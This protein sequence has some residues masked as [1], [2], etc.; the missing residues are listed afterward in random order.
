MKTLKSFMSFFTPSRKYKRNKRNKITKKRNN[1][2][3]RKFKMRGG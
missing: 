3:K 2:I 1:K